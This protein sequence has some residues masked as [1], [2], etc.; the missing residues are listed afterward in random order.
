MPAPVR[1]EAANARPCLARRMKSGPE[2]E[3]VLD[4]R[5]LRPGG[6][7]EYSRRQHHKLATKTGNDRR[8]LGESNR[9]NESARG[10]AKEY[11]RN[12]AVAETGGKSTEARQSENSRVENGAEQRKSGRMLRKNEQEGNSFSALGENQFSTRGPEKS[13][14]DQ[15]QETK[16]QDRQENK[17]K[18]WARPTKS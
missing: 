2:Q 10:H 11:G 3:T 7:E 13:A 15:D 17:K 1:T 4:V 12:Q 6:D 18:L 9:L 16:K 14:Q 5:Q 8:G